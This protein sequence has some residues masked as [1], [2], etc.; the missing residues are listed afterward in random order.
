M[1]TNNRFLKFIE[2]GEIKVKKPIDYSQG[3]AERLLE[4]YKPTKG[5]SSIDGGSKD[6]EKELAA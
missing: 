5:L 3:I 2:E 1:K 6:I 4:K